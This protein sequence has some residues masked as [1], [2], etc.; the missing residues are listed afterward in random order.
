MIDF[1]SKFLTHVIGWPINL[2]Q[3][4]KSKVL[5]LVFVLPAMSMFIVMLMVLGIP[6]CLLVFIACIYDLVNNIS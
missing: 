1:A 6:F 3:K 4:L 2:F 5:R